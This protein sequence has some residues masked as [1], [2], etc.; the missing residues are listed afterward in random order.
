MNHGPQF[1]S[2]STEERRQVFFFQFC[3]SEDWMEKEL[4]SEMLWFQ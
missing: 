1:E 3:S 4:I 2:S